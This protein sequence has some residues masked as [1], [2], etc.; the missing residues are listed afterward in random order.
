MSSKLKTKVSSN[1]VALPRIEE[2]KIPFPCGSLNRMLRQN[3]TVRDA[4]RRKIQ[5]DA[6]FFV[7]R[8]RIKPFSPKSLVYFEWTWLVSSKSLATFNRRDGDNIS[9]AGRK[10]L[11]DVLVKEEI[12]KDDCFKYIGSP[13]LDWFEFVGKKESGVLIRISDVPLYCGQII[14]VE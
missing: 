13:V 6:T 4:S 14:R 11:L 1:V 10:L 2:I 3:W 12:V 9:S 5:E 7:R 8:F